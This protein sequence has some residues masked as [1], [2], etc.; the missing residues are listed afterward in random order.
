MRR[1]TD[2]GALYLSL[3]AVILHFVIARA[4]MR[5]WRGARPLCARVPSTRYR[6][7]TNLTA[8]STS[9]LSQVQLSDPVSP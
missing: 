8:V 2:A 1:S 4:R 6:P 5:I 9:E 3:S 7:P